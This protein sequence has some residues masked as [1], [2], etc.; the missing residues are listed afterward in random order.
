MLIL[1]MVGGG[2]LQPTNRD[3]LTIDFI[4]AA[5]RLTWTRAG[6]A[7]DAWYDIGVTV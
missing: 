4:S 7:E 3:R 5:D 1:T 6:A 2:T